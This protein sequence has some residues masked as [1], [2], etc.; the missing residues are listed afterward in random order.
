MPPTRTAQPRGPRPRPTQL[1]LLHGDRKDR[2]NQHEPTPRQSLPELPDGASADVREVW[3]YTLR[4]LIAMKIAHAADRDALLCYCEA[5]VT[6]RKAS[7]LLAKSHVLVQGRDGGLVRNPV[8]Q[9]QR[10]AAT[11]IRGFAQEFGL[12]PS[13]RTRIE[14]PDDDARA[15][16]PFAQSG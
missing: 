16:N 11:T 5:V 10:D 12:T 8:I 9:I 4:E 7:A 15:D 1:K 2:I 13:A 3:D 6:H 14:A